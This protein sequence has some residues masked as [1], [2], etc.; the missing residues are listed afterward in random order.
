[1]TLR[2]IF[3]FSVFAG[4]SFGFAYKIGE[5]NPEIGSGFTFLNLISNYADSSIQVFLTLI[6]LVFTIF[7][8][9]KLATFFKQVYESRLNGVVTAILGFFGSLF[10]V[11]VHQNGIPLFGLGIGL[12][13]IGTTIII[14]HDKKDQIKQL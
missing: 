5:T 6:S 10:V 7:F 2:K 14:L 3:L 1:L 13:I 9:F 8:I 11:F 4:I 12:L